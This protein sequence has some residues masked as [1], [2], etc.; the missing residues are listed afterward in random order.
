MTEQRPGA[1]SVVHSF[2]PTVILLSLLLT[3]GFFTANSIFNKHFRQYKSAKDIPEALFKKQW[4]YG[5]VTAV[6][7]GD[8]FHF[9]HT[10]GGVLGGW[11]SLRSVP[12]LQVVANDASTEVPQSGS[13]WQKL[14]NNKVSNYKQHF[15]SLHVP[16]RG[17]RSLPTISVRLCGV[18][19]PER[20]HFGKDAQPFSDEAMNW[21]R[22]K[23]LGQR[24]WIKPL[25]VDQYGRCIARVERW[26]WYKGWQNISIEMLKEGL[27]VVYEGKVNAEF[28]NQE[29]IYRYEEAIS[30]NAKRGLW[31][32]RKFE[33]PGAFKKRT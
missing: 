5:K 23:I 30:K 4:L 2:Y 32:M 25:A 17:R 3:G 8:N 1:N 7:D 11:G 15:M 14:F 18:D 20:A 10:P 24:V 33:S 29:N 6:G 9:F 31:S 12:K 26:S 19:A 13:W 21:L 22:Y 16:Y 28:D 27:G